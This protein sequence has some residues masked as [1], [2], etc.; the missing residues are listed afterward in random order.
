MIINLTEEQANILAGLLGNINV[1]TTD[2]ALEKIKIHIGNKYYV[3]ELQHRNKL[4]NTT[5]GEFF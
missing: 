1:N 2:D 4:A 3:D 5:S